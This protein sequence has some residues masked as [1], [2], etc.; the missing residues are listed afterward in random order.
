MDVARASEE[1]L[2]FRDGDRVFSDL[3]SNAIARV[4]GL[5]GE[6]VLVVGADGTIRDAAGTGRDI[7]DIGSWIG[8]S[9][10]EIV[11]VES[12]AKVAE[13]LAPGATDETRW[14]QVNH[15]TDIGEVPVRY[16]VVH[17]REDGELIAIGRDLREA[18][19]LQQ[20]LLRA[21][22][23]LERDYLRLRQAESRYRLL[24]DLSDEPMLII[25]ART[26]RVREANPAARHLLRTAT[27]SPVGQP[28]SM[29]FASDSREALLGYLGATTANDRVQTIDARIADGD[30]SVRVVA[31]SFRQHDTLYHLLRLSDATSSPRAE[32]HPLAEVVQHLPDAFV[33]VDP[34][35]AIV[36]ANDAFV[37]LVQAASLDLVR[38]KP[39]GQFIGRPGVDLPLIL[40]QVSEHGVARNVATIVNSLDG[41]QEPVELS[42]VGGESVYGHYGF[43][44]RHVGR[45][46]RDL[47][48]AA[49]GAPRSVEQLTEL[50]GRMSLKDIV[51]ESTDLIERLC[52]EAALTITSNNRASAAE[53]LGLSRQSLYSKLHRHGLGNLGDPK[54]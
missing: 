18:A 44:L 17:L 43:S 42:A 45:R 27:A 37:E 41:V 21:Q 24:F 20:R 26:Q 8:K 34:A 38:G 32:A 5:A 22:Q 31:S 30:G 50:V 25:D 40:A 1:T 3:S 47:P 36:T 49:T 51:R 28:V 35:L 29:L 16:R 11:T 46:L 23:S 13:L 6:I 9:W 4:A 2:P 39:L 14:R 15:L 33:L 19:A 12:R 48:P 54:D 10:A 53:I 7:P 52:I